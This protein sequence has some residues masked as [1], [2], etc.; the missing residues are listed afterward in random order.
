M[1]IEFWKADVTLHQPICC[2]PPY[3]RLCDS[4]E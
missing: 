3:N 4:I 1:V 2:L